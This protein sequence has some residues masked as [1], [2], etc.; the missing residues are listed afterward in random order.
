MGCERLQNQ[1]G[2]VL[3]SSLTILTVLL[4]MGI[5]VHVMLQNDYRVLANLRSG[6]EA[7]YISVAGLEWSK[8]EIARAATFPPSP[9]NQTRNFAT[10]EFAVSFLSPIVVGPLTAKLVVHSVGTIG[11]SS[12]VVE[13]QLTK[14]YDLADAAI[15]VRGNASRINFSGNS[16]FI[17]GVDHDPT[18]KKP[19]P[20]AQ[21]R[22]AISASDETLRGLVTEALGDSL[23]QGVLDA[24]SANPVVGTSNF[25][26]KAVISQ[27]AGGLCGSPGVSIT[28]IPDEGSLVLENQAWGTQA[29]PQ[30]RCIE[31]LPTSGDRVTLNGNITGAGILIIKDADLIVSGSFH[32]EGLIIITGDEVG[33]KV[34]GSSSKEVFG[35]VIVNETGSPGSS[36]AILDIQGNFRLLFSRQAFGRAASLIPKPILANTYTALPSVIS[37]Q[38]WRTVSP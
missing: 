26:P 7:F 19:V 25:L 38:Y 24:G 32:W 15:G 20:G 4:V 35:A 11:S 29:L 18:T 28:S 30:L 8:N 14:A 12:H 9:V 31:G 27:M 17:S 6:T 37:Q 23:Q 36:T 10:G 34:I 13:A 5:A 16:F 22:P 21:A 1:R 3:F 2:M 33:L